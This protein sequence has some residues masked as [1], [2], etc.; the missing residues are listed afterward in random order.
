VVVVVVEVAQAAVVECGSA[1]QRGA[2]GSAWRHGCT[3]CLGRGHGETR[4]GWRAAGAP[5]RGRL[6]SG[7]ASRQLELPRAEHR[8]ETSRRSFCAEGPAA[9]FKGRV[10]VQREDWG[11]SW[12][13]CRTLNVVFTVHARSWRANRMST[14]GVSVLGSVLGCTCWL[15]IKI[16][17]TGERKSPYPLVVP[18]FISILYI[19]NPPQSSKSIKHVQ[20]APIVSKKKG[21]CD[22][23]QWPDSQPTVGLS[24]ATSLSDSF[25]LKKTKQQQ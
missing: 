12:G 7:R 6:P 13:Q 22:A 10:V 5:S 18:C 17:P 3:G 24:P 23:G 1:G 2:D 9:C 8:E 16:S 11:W 20:T 4:C 21:P 19:Q 14:S 25:A 15:C